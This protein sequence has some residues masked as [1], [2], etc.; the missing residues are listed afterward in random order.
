MR[1]RERERERETKMMLFFRALAD[2]NP[3]LASSRGA[4]PEGNLGRLEGVKADCFEWLRGGGEKVRSRSLMPRVPVFPY[5]RP[6]TQATRA[7]ATPTKY[8]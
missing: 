4:R 8:I 7:C 1:E 6:L 2:K 5:A 3:V